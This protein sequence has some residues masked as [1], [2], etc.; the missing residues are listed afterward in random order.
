MTVPAGDR[1]VP[2]SPFFPGMTLHDR[3]TLRDRIGLGG[4][5][6]VWS[7]DDQVLGRAVA[8]KVLAVPLAADPVLRAATWREARAAAQLTHPHV[9][10]VY[11]YGEATLPGGEVVPFLVMELVAGESLADR[12]Q[13]GPLPWPEAVRVGAQV[14]SALAAAHALGIVHRDIK[15]G[16]VM[17]TPSGARVLDFGIAALAGGS[18]TDAG[19]LVGTPA[20]AA[21][22]RL[23]AAPAAPASD[24]YALGV[25]LYEA[26]TGHQLVPAASW[27]GA[28]NMHRA[29]VPVP[30]LDVPGL[31]RRVSR[32]CLACVAPDPDDRPIAEELASGL[33]AASPTPLGTATLPSAPARPAESGYAVGSAPLPRPATV[34]EPAAAVA[35]PPAAAPSPPSRRPLLFVLVSAVVVVGF[36]LALVAAALLS[37]GAGHR[38]AQANA[39]S[40]TETAT[41]P[42][43][44]PPESPAASGASASSIVD[45]LDQTISDA[46][47][48]G[49]LDAATAQL[50]R[51][52]INELR[53]T[54]G[55]GR[56]RKQEQALKKTISGLVSDGKLDQGTADR[57]TA[58]LDALVGAG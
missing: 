24:V 11:D 57:L 31:P 21:P 56:A 52:K 23:R 3:F 6:E 55:R 39:P 26:L 15:P 38:T 35:D 34:I 1:L 27:Q 45:Q 22:E 46:L 4:M 10:Q 30:P 2:M 48:A 51:D 50:L 44:E 43:S 47:A 18:D 19:R 20:Y 54:A 17:L 9:T 58:L 5:S 25:L 13:S 42:T 33:A 7:A 8:V 32:L 40:A 16:N 49:H 29:G 41:A 37:G 36:V 12:L 53:G 28:A 14:A